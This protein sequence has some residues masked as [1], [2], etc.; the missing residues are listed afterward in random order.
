MKNFK[1]GDLVLVG[2]VGSEE[3]GLFIG[4]NP[5]AIAGILN[6]CKVLVGDKI[7][8]LYLG[9]IKKYETGTR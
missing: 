3:L 4:Y 8:D 2:Y 5:T 9:L 7:C 6:S 1:P